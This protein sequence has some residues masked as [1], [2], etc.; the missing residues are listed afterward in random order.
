VSKVAVTVT[1]LRVGVLKI[2]V[3]TKRPC[4]ALSPV[5]KG[6]QVRL[7]IWPSLTS[8]ASPEASTWPWVSAEQDDDR[9]AYCTILDFVTS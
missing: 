4:V 8:T 2:S 6:K 3:G 7:D 5:T 9:V 1:S